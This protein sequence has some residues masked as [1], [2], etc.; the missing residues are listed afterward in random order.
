MQYIEN[1]YLV[2]E[3][4]NI[5]LSIDKIISQIPPI[6]IRGIDFHLLASSEYY[7]KTEYS[8]KL[9]R[10]PW[11]SF[12]LTHSGSTKYHFPNN[13]ILV[14]TND[15][16]FIPPGVL[17]CWE[18][19]DLPLQM[20]GVVFE[21][22]SDDSNLESALL[23]LRQA[24]VHSSFCFP[25]TNTKLSE[26]LA[27][28]F[29]SAHPNQNLFAENVQTLLA[30]FLVMSLEMTMGDIIE[31]FRKD[32]QPQ[33]AS[34]AKRVVYRIQSYIQANLDQKLTRKNIAA[35]I[36][37]SVRHMNRLFQNETDQSIGAYIHSYKLA[38]A[39]QLL[40]QSD[41]SIKEIAYSLGYR[42]LSSFYRMIHYHFGKTPATIRR[43]FKLQIL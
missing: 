31:E 39:K 33:K 11:F 5:S 19:I 42:E 10:H 15:L 16:L 2:T 35:Q 43:Q 34:Y 41:I 30:R 21:I 25:L 6:R 27:E 20:R 7:T 18:S 23:S 38:R 24:L 29:E 8:V 28:L 1:T 22:S 17:H 4:K 26:V 12:I 13:D 9:H 37:L 14:G 36:N 40:E 3:D 32:T